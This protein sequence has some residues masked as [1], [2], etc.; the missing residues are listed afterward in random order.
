MSAISCPVIVVPLASLDGFV[1]TARIVGST[2]R[3]E[4]VD[5]DSTDRE[6][7]NEQAPQDLVWHWAAGPQ[8]FHCN[9][10]TSVLFDI[11]I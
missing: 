10:N 8:D 5:D 4:P 9:T 1:S 11:L 6:E 2:V 3:E 7:E